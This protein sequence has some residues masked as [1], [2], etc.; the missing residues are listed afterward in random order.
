MAAATAT[1]GI[2]DRIGSTLFFA[3][4]AHGVVILGVTF[5]PGPPAATDEMPALNVTLLVDTQTVEAPNADAE[6]LASRDQQGGGSNDS[7]RPTRT[8]A[9]QPQASQL[10]SPLGADDRDADPLD[11]ATPIEQL[12]SR[13]PSSREVEAIPDT[14]DDAAPVPMTAAER[15]QQDS[16]STLAAELDLV[17]RN[18]NSDDNAAEAPSTREAVVAAY[19]VGW[20]QRVERIGTANFPS[21]LREAGNDH[22]R[23][24]VEV[25]IDAAGTLDDIVLRRSSGDARLDQAALRILRLAAPFEPL[26]QEMLAEYDV[27]RFAYEWDFSTGPR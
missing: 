10:G 18:M 4:L 13:S 12:V 2:A 17:V 27:L 11:A 1:A 23:P 19:M 6:L 22:G 9:A 8:L 20:R 25:A 21:E 24:V 26:P 15:L 7:T 14:T 16:P 5:A 3:A